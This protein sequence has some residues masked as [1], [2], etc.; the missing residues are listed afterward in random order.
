MHSSGI[1]EQPCGERVLKEIKAKRQDSQS[2]TNKEEVPQNRTNVWELGNRSKKSKLK[3]I[4]S[5]Q[6]PRKYRLAGGG[7]DNEPQTVAPDRLGG[8]R[9]N[10]RAREEG[11]LGG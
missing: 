6:R 4:Q 11:A 2:R 5:L 10:T 7:E 1:R 3:V 8:N 9:N